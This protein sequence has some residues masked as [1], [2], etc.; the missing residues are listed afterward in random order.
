M[1]LV[2]LDINAG[3]HIINSV[4][5]N[6]NPVKTWRSPVVTRGAIHRPAAAISPDTPPPNSSASASTNSEL[7]DS[8]IDTDSRKRLFDQIRI[9]PGASVPSASA[10][11]ESIAASSSPG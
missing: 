2:E 1:P 6:S 3:M 11:D 10:V 8:R 4:D 7:F 9:S 5:S